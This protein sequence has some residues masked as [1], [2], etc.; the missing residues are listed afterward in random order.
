MK[1]KI[2]Y[3]DRNN[4]KFSLFEWLHNSIFPILKEDIFTFSFKFSLTFM[5]LTSIS[6]IVGNFISPADIKILSMRLN[7]K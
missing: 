7:L 5:A 6:L 1:E 3:L 4:F 2:G